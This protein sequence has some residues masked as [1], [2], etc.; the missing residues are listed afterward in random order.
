MMY[1]G[2]IIEESLENKDILKRLSIISTRIEKVTDKHQT[3]WLSQW[4]LHTIEI[5]EIEA[6]K[7]AQELSGSID[8][9]HIGSW[10]IDFRNNTKHLVV[11][12]DKVFH[13]DRGSKLQYD[14]MR[15]YGVLLG[16]PEYQLPNYQDLP[17]DVLS[18]FLKEANKNT[19]ANKD[20]LKAESSR[21]GSE[22]YHFKKDGLI[23]HDTYFGTRYFIGEEIIYRNNRPVWGMNYQGYV[24]SSTVEEKELY[25]FLKEAL[26][27]EYSEII[28]V[29]GPRRYTNREWGYVNMPIGELSRFTGTEEIYR[30]DELLYRAYYHGGLIE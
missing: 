12:R 8:I 30:R 2:D 10:Y 13:I 25:E 11:F 16:M 26:M 9:N 4:T 19:Y 29:R 23:Y 22:D 21:L 27:Q 7:V 17:M 3:P 1:K 14:E 5:K 15:E 20:A 28:P 18:S 24:L 6:E